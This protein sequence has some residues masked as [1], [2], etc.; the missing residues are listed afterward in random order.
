MG[1]MSLSTLCLEC[2]LCCDGTLFRRVKISAPERAELVALGIGV[3]EQKQ[4]D[5]MWLPC[6]K[7]SG[8]CCGIYEARPGGCRRFVCALG[9][10]LVRNEVSLEEAREHVVEMQERIATLREVFPPPGGEPVLRHARA[11]ID[12]TTTKVSQAQL[13]AFQRVEEIRYAVFMPPP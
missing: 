6:G 13:E 12:S 10:R 5:V 1:L 3:G 9:E 7:L 4:H 2:G 11:S 8:K